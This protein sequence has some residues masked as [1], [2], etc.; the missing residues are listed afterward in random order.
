MGD[1]EP[2]K[3]K[4]I[5][6]E[7][8]VGNIYTNEEI[9]QTLNH[10]KIDLDSHCLQIRGWTER[11]TP[12][13]FSAKYGL[14]ELTKK[15]LNAN[16][17]PN[18][19]ENVS[20]LR[21]I[22]S[23]EANCKEYPLILAAKNAKHEILHLLKFH[24]RLPVDITTDVDESGVY[25]EST[26]SNKP[27]LYDRTT[28]FT[29]TDPFF[30]ETVLHIVLWPFLLRPKE[31]LIFDKKSANFQGEIPP[32][33]FSDKIGLALAENYRKCI[34]VLLDLDSFEEDRTLKQQY[35]S[36]IHQIINYQA[37][38]NNTA[39]HY[40]VSY[41]SSDV[42]ENLLSLGADA[43]MKNKNGKIPLLG[44]SN[45][46]FRNFMDTKCIETVDRLLPNKA[47]VERNC[48]ESDIKFD[49][50]FL[51]PPKAPKQGM[52]FPRYDKETKKADKDVESGLNIQPSMPE[53]SLIA[54]MSESK[55]HRNLITHPVIDS[56]VWLKWGLM[57]RYFHS[58]L[59]LRFLFTYCVTWYI[60]S[61]FVGHQ[62][63]YANWFRKE[64]NITKGIFGHQS[65]GLGFTDLE[66]ASPFS[67]SSTLYFLFM[68]VLGLQIIWIGITFSKKRTH[69]VFDGFTILLN[70]TLLVFGGDQ[71]L[72][73]IL[74]L[75]L[76]YYTMDEIGQMYVAYPSAAYFRRI[77]NYG[78]LTVLTF[79]LL[80]L[81]GPD[82]MGEHVHGAETTPHIHYFPTLEQSH[83]EK[84]SYLAKR[85]MGAIVLVFVWSRFLTEV[86]KL[87]S[88]KTSMIHVAMFYKVAKHYVKMMLIY[89]W[90]LITFGLG[91][92]IMLHFDTG[93][94]YYP[95]F[96]IRHH[97]T[98]NIDSISNS[99]SDTDLQI[100]KPSTLPAK[101]K[102]ANN[103]FL[104]MLKTSTMFL[105][106]FDF[107][108][109]PIRGGS[110]IV[111]LASL[112]SL[113]FI[114]FMIIVLMNVLN[115]LA[116]NDIPPDSQD[117]FLVQCQVG[118]IN[119]LQN[120]ETDKMNELFDH[121]N[122]S[123]MLQQCYAP[124][125]VFLFKENKDVATKDGLTIQKDGMKLTFSK[126][127]VGHEEK[128][129]FFWR[130]CKS[131]LKSGIRG[132]QIADIGVFLSGARKVLSKRHM[133]HFYVNS[134]EIKA[135][136]KTEISDEINKFGLENS[137][138][139]LRLRVEVL[140][141]KMDK[142]EKYI[143][144]H[145]DEKID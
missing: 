99:T 98:M 118:R 106:E 96:D 111:T 134:T 42:V 85:S 142:I 116:I 53:M 5:K 110:I 44:I 135:P 19:V 56:F 139:K 127:K 10:E 1:N 48:Q 105:G 16:V 55:E 84:T 30:D 100:T 40:A 22:S 125:N 95:D 113:S 68:I 34:D 39:L 32:M 114:F 133:Q 124:R 33:I 129:Y 121:F 66:R 50:T 15:L 58:K 102:K 90:Y 52:S 45:N 18:T 49:Y 4:I 97:A 94:S 11:Y 131:V 63:Y 140:I 132:Y 69:F 23:T 17:D 120:L 46:S 122:I 117:E 70:M 89:V 145:V 136:I 104:V 67:P 130:T 51:C 79:I 81:Y 27:L 28:D 59:R 2:F 61:T 24:N 35:I 137:Q 88:F 37:S 101:R 144:A 9:W 29:V 36:Q 91:F 143:G 60:F 86:L 57:Y 71:I 92:Y 93:S 108:D 83:Y 43:N 64:T 13:Q 74:T 26:R 82:N 78:D 20:N 87:P 141:N 73:F 80:I 76:F 126:R 112:F 47:M 115:A 138:L 41:C 6:V 72:W 25:A 109:L 75:L 38:K 21:N 107:E 65:Y 31:L 3:D 7:N 12:M 103:I 62:W 8:P 128:G 119:C 14:K 123:K 77:S 54:Q